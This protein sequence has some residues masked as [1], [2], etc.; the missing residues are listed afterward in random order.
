MRVFWLPFVILAL[1]S[2]SCS[3][4]RCHPS[5]DSVDDE[6]EAIKNG[7]CAV[8]G[9]LFEDSLSC[10]KVEGPCPGKRGEASAK[11]A[12]DPDRLADPDLDWAREQ[13]GACSC[14]CCHHIGAIAD[15]KWAWDFDPVWTVSAESSVLREL[16]STA[17][18]EYRI[19]AA[20][21]NG[22]SVRELHLPTTDPAR[23]QAFIARELERR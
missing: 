17:D 12:D 19:E 10:S 1:F 23:M 4:D 21:N 13:L 9:T 7:T 2:M 14:S 8:Q 5:G 18:A 16:N 22:F 6:D 11:V 20:S 3:A 15:H